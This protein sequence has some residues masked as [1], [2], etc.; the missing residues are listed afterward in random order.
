MN[1]RSIND[2]LGGNGLKQTRDKWSLSKHCFVGLGPLC[3]MGRIRDYNTVTHGDRR[4][5]MRHLINFYLQTNVASN[6]ERK[7][8]FTSA[9]KQL[10]L[11]F[12][13]IFLGTVGLWRVVNRWVSYFFVSYNL[14]Q[15]TPQQSSGHN[16]K[17][18]DS[19][20]HSSAYANVSDHGC[21]EFV[22]NL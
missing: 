18:K 7:V 2:H 11:S 13:H 19:E 4:A 1:V 16:S 8:M 12:C 22:A 9:L 14:L 3:I 21:P 6:T 15:R 17:V 5:I 10:L 20:E